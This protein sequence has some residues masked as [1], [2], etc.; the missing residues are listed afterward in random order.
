MRLLTVG[1]M[2]L[3]GVVVEGNG[4]SLPDKL[5]MDDLR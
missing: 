4:M 5:D 3:V 2:R 1:K